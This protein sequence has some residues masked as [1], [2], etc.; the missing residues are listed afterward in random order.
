MLNF[1]STH[2]KI[3]N[4]NYKHDELK[5]ERQWNCTKK[6]TEKEKVSREE[7]QKSRKYR[8]RKV[9]MTANDENERFVKCAQK[10]LPT[11]VMFIFGSFACLT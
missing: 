4:L 5:R 9:Q 3:P 7:A 11:T 6:K 8:V 2:A 1:V 10:K